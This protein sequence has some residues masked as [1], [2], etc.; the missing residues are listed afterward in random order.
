MASDV[1]RNFQSQT[2]PVSVPTPRIDDAM[3]SLNDAL[4]DLGKLRI[5]TDACK[6]N[7]NLT[8]TEARASIDAFV[9][10][11]QNM[12]V[13]DMFA[14][15]IDIELLR[16]LPDIIKSP[17]VNIDAGM[18][19]LYYNAL[20]Y[21]LHQI[22]GPGD[23]VAQGMYLKVLE[24]VPAWLDAQKDTDMDGHTAALTAWTAINN[25]D[26]QLS[27]KFHCKSCHFVKSRKIDQ[28]DVIPARSFEE[29]DKR[30]SLR[31]LYWHVL[32]TDTLFRLFYGKPTMVC[33]CFR[34]HSTHLLSPYFM[35]SPFEPTRLLQLKLIA[36]I[37]QVALICTN[38]ISGSMD[39]EQDTPSEHYSNKKHESID[40]TSHGVGGVD[41]IHDHD[42]R[43]AQRD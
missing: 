24:A 11:L 27:W 23:P 22:R 1:R 2:T 15:P 7:L 6:A 33:S 5:R 14:I 37:D 42:S 28:L 29:E 32:G 4:D 3:S 17:Y 43:N 16:M 36:Y 26:Y 8:S 30:D 20:Y 41:Q 34:V 19:V 12:I 18:Y 10:F 31:Y 39:T 25:H 9:H 35:T 13:P 21:G 40:H 38:T